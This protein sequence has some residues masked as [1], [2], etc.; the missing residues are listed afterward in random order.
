MDKPVSLDEFLQ[1]QLRDPE[2][3]KEYAALEAEFDS[4]RARIEKQLQSAE[5]EE[6][7]DES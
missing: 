3:R 4:E 5:P 7:S 2:F 1:Q 6:N